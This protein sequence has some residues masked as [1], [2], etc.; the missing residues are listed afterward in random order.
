MD[1]LKTYLQDNP[2][3]IEILDTLLE[4]ERENKTPDNPWIQDKEYDSV[5]THSDVKVSPQRLY[6]LEVKGVLDRIIDTNSTTG[7]CIINRCGVKSTIEE[8]K[9]IQEQD[10][11][12]IIHSFPDEEDLEGVFDDVIGYEKV[13]WLFKRGMSTDEI[14]N[15]LLVG[16]PGSAKTVFLMCI[17][18]LD[19]A[20]FVPATETSA[21]GFINMLFEDRPKYMLFDELDDAEKEDQ[22]SLSQYTETGIVRETKYGKKRAIKTNTK[23]FATANHIDQIMGH[24]KDRFTILH[25]DAYDYDDY[26][27]VCEHILPKNE[28]KTKQ[29]ARLIADALWERSGTG[30]VRQAIQVSR[31]SRGDPEKVIDVL[32]EYSDS[33]IRSKF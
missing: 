26:A 7:Y 15:F 23:T 19:G 13:K 12:E 5:W 29:E 1:S 8:V 33:S 9:K 22:K 2:E 4:Y 11:E 10:Y 21:S 3:Y 18:K 16:P 24:I 32:D 27:E 17:S 25:F 6:Q 31:L 30:D 28:G 14:T 20:E